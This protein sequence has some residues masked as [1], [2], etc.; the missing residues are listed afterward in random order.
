MEGQNLKF[1]SKITLDYHTIC[2][3]EKTRRLKVKMVGLGL[4]LDIRIPVSL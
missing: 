4:G 2:A 3:I 1:F